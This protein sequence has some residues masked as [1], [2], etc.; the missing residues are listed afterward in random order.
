[1][2]DRDAAASAAVAT[3]T[4]ISL[5]RRPARDAVSVAAADLSLPS[6]LVVRCVSSD[7]VCT[8]LVVVEVASHCRPRHFVADNC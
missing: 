5:A 6:V 4:V 3:G 7:I 1:M 8:A 2:L